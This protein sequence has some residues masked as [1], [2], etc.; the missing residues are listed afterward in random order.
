MMEMHTSSPSCRTVGPSVFAMRL[1]DS[2]A[3]LVK[4]TSAGSVA[5][6]KRATLAR[7]SS[8]ACVAS[9]ESW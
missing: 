6:T 8:M 4:T 2:L 5:P 7:A 1:S 9:T 3:F